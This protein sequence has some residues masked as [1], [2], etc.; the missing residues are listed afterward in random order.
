M[1]DAFDVMLY[2][3]V[4]THIMRDLGMS[5]S[6]AGLLNTLTLLASGI[7]GVFFGFPAGWDANAR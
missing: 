7:G 5:K 6:T 4:L 2:A 3:L 1:L